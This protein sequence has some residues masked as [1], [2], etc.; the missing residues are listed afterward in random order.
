MKTISFACSRS[1]PMLAT[2]KDYIFFHQGYACED[3][4]S[5]VYCEDILILEFEIFL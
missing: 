1:S 2:V 5:L 3:I 4:L